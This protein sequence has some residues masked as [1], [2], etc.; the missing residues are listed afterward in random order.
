LETTGKPIVKIGRFAMGGD[1]AHL[2]AGDAEGE[3]LRWALGKAIDKSRVDFVHA[4]GT[5]TVQHDP[6]ELAA[7]EATLRPGDDPPVYSHKAA[8]GHSLGAAGLVSV[9]LNCLVH[10]TGMI[11]PNVNTSEPLE[12]RLKISREI[13]RRSVRRSLAVASGFG[14][15]LAA[16]SL[17]NVE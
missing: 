17:E 10:Q 15:A 11:P 6:V 13:Q 5:G 1:A 4:H 12:S 9:V 2:T 3:T 16:V 8:L 14:G 7:L